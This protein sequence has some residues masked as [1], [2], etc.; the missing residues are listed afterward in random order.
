M[1]LN[2]GHSGARWTWTV[3]QT[4][5]RALAIDNQMM[6]KFV[7][8]FSQ[9]HTTVLRSL[10]GLPIEF[11]SSHAGKNYVGEKWWKNAFFCKL[12]Q[13]HSLL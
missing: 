3:L 6:T 10:G 12:E 4:A 11:H 13:I 7:D 1:H 8:S 5:C 9:K 2:K